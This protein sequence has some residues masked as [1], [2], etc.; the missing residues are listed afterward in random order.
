MALINFIL[1]CLLIWIMQLL[2]CGLLR[3]KHARPD[4]NKLHSKEKSNKFKN[5][6]VGVKLH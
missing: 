1:V 3:I 2:V 4:R 6:Y 5:I